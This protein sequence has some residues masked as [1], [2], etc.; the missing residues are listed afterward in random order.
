[1]V[2]AQV[3][4]RVKVTVMARAAAAQVDI[5]SGPTL[6]L[7]SPIQSSLVQVVLG[8]QRLQVEATAD[9]Q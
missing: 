1:V 7:L 8:D 2:A 3:V 6:H 5:A 4:D 9:H